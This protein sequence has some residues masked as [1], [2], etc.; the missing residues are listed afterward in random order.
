MVGVGRERDEKRK[1]VAK[2]K[3]AEK[4]GEGWSIHNGNNAVYLAILQ[5]YPL[6][7]QTT[8]HFVLITYE[9]F[10]GIRREYQDRDRLPGIEDI[11]LPHN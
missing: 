3:K 10:L 5:R 1:E 6:K 9:R 4:L 8:K 2:R 11:W 7:I